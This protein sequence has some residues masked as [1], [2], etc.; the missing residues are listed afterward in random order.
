MEHLLNAVETAIRQQNW[1]A[2]LATALALPDICGWTEDPQAKSKARYVNWFDRFLRPLYTRQI[3]A[4]GRELTFLTGND[5][6]AL[7][8]AVL[9]EGRDD[10]TDQA[11]REVVERF[12][13]IIAPPGYRVHLNMFGSQ[14][15]LQVDQFCADMVS[16]VRSWW[17]TTQGSPEVESRIGALLRL[18]DINGNVI[19]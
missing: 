12:E 13:F 7:R 1:Y 14:L 19:E 6:Y 2:A 4:D 8:C 18:R 16:A 17:G 9:H 11:A 5:C 10:I 3:G 15:Q